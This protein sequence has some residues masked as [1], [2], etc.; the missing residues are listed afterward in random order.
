MSGAPTAAAALREAGLALLAAADAMTEI[1]PG[2]GNHTSAAQGRV[3][4]APSPRPAGDQSANSDVSSSNSAFAAMSLPAA[5]ALLPHRGPRGGRYTEEQEATLRRMAWQGHSDPEIAEALCRMPG[6][7]LPTAGAIAKK[8]VKEGIA[9]GRDAVRRPPATII[10][11]GQAPTAA[12]RARANPKGTRL[13]T[14]SF[15]ER[16]AGERGLCNGG[17]PLDLNKINAKARELGLPDF[18]LDPPPR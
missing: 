7:A 9:P 1:L 12:M 13:A 10:P 18:V 4:A 17:E 16:W 6:G 15:I 14:R 5:K 8:R 2:K 3:A 11:A